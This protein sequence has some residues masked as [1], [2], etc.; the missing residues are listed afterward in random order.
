MSALIG[1]KAGSAIGG[2]FSNVTKLADHAHANRQ[3]QRLNSILNVF[4]N[5][6]QNSI[7]RLQLREAQFA[8]GP[9]LFLTFYRF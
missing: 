6:L 2:V 9:L 3:N 5:N 7:A 8:A 1:V 4:V